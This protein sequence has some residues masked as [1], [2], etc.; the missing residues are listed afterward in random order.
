MKE[1][2]KFVHQSVIRLLSYMTNLEF[3]NEP[4]DQ[5]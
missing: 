5:C 4:N 2:I 1:I 3:P